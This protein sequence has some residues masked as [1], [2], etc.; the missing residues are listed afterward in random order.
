MNW[1]STDD[2]CRLTG[3]TYRRLDYWARLQPTVLGPFDP[4]D[5]S[6]SRRRY[7]ADD[8]A[9]LRRAARFV[10][11]TDALTKGGGVPIE[12]V[13]DF[14]ES[15]SGSGPWS[16]ECGPL[17]ALS[18]YASDGLTNDQRRRQAILAQA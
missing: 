12:V 6:G 1:Y 15:T 9:R 5:G 17:A 7:S 10:E 18:I 16:Y 14:V 2:V 8:L 3:L 13:A 4:G 11:A